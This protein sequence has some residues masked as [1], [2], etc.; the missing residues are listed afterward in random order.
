MKFNKDISNL[1][2][3]ILKIENP[4]YRFLFQILYSRDLPD[5]RMMDYFTIKIKNFNKK[6]D[7][8]L[9]VGGV[10]VFN[11]LIKVPMKFPRKFVLPEE[12]KKICKK[13]I[14]ILKKTQ[15]KLITDS[16][17]SYTK[18]TGRLAKQVGIEKT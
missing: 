17:D 18:K 14:P 15:D 4:V 12:L 11:A 3:N 9:S 16:Q 1:S 8:Y 2:E 13:L 6:I 7:N 10:L 5:Y